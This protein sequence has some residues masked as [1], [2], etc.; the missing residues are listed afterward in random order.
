MFEASE[1]DEDQS[2]RRDDLAVESIHQQMEV[3]LEDRQFQ[4]YLQKLLNNPLVSNIKEQLRLLSGEAVVKTYGKRKAAILLTLFAG[5]VVSFIGSLTFLV[6]KQFPTEFGN[7]TGISVDNEVAD[8]S[9]Q[10]LGWTNVAIEAI[11]YTWTISGILPAFQPKPKQEKSNDPN[12]VGFFRR[13]YDKFGSYLPSFGEWT[14]AVASTIPL[15]LLSLNSENLG[16]EEE[17]DDSNVIKYGI[18]SSIALVT[19]VS[20]KYFLTLTH[21]QFK[22]V[23]NW[24]WN[25]NKTEEVSLDLLKQV[26][27]A[28]SKAA[29]RANEKLHHLTKE[30][31]AATIVSLNSLIPKGNNLED[32]VSEL[33][34]QHLLP[35]I[36]KD[37]SY[38]S[39]KVNKK[40]IVFV[41]A[42]AIFAALSWLGLIATVPN[43]VKENISSS[44]AA[45]YLLMVIAGIPLIEIGLS[46]GGSVGLRLSRM[47]HI[48]T[49]TTN[50]TNW[51]IRLLGYIPL[52]LFGL[53]SFGTN[54][55]LTI[56][57]FKTVPAVT[58][59]LLPSATLGIDLINIFAGTELWDQAST[60]VSVAFNKDKQL[61][62]KYQR[63]LE[64]LVDK[65]DI[66]SEES[67]A[68][69]LL[70][71]EPEIQDKIKQ[72][73]P[74][75]K[76]QGSDEF[77]EAVSQQLHLRW[78]DVQRQQK[79]ELPPPSIKENAA[80]R[81]ILFKWGGAKKGKSTGAKK[82]MEL[83]SYSAPQYE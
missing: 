82:E 28:F 37:L 35:I 20:N 74:S 65:I 61:I 25:K 66:V 68:A 48:D 69:L 15:T 24:L 4:E 57:Q 71:L 40:T 38:I 10:F 58:W 21:K 60:S 47:G 78:L 51:K 5:A 27:I 2:A 16:S 72:F 63:F 34:W 13:C 6:G 46:A 64:A 26:K 75:M 49:L 76:M 42:M 12:N 17:K 70:K 9:G 45:Q 14:L 32:Q 77:I 81:H 33:R 79:I 54:A 7:F 52:G 80:S 73:I 23:W 39:P 8:G 3:M 43:A 18:V 31:F 83:D 59:M 29:V 11:F 36:F 67:L 62:V 53:F 30:E 56:Q 22:S 19:L 55:T 1:L 50:L 41:P 44:P